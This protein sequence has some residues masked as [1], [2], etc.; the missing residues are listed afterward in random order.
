MTFPFQA[1]RYESAPPHQQQWTPPFLASLSFIN[2]P[3]TIEG[4]AFSWWEYMMSGLVSQLNFYHKIWGA[5]Q[6][7]QSEHCQEKS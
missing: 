4:I 7:W 2:S 6:L 3:F 5:V 1:Q